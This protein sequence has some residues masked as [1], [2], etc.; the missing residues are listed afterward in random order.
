MPQTVLNEKRNKVS[1]TTRARKSKLKLLCP[2]KT[3]GKEKKKK[4]KNRKMEQAPMLLTWYATAL[5]EKLSSTNMMS[6]LIIKLT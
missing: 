6:C 5:D 1:R 3:V 2:G 4:K